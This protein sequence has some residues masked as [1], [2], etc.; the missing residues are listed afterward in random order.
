M[1]IKPEAYT[2]LALVVH[3][4]VTNSAKYGSLCDSNGRLNVDVASNKIGD[5]E[6][7]WRETGGPPVKPPRR[8][9]FGSTIIERSIPFELKGEAELR[10][11]L[12]GLEADFLVPSRFVEMARSRHGA[13]DAQGAGSPTTANAPAAS[14]GLPEHVLIVEDSMIIAL[15]TEECLKRLG[16]KYVTVEG[17]VNGALKAIENR[18]PDFALV[19]FNLGTESSEPVAEELKRRG[20]RFALATGYSDVSRRLDELGACA[21][22]HK[23][24]GIE[25]IEAL[26]LPEAKDEAA[27]QSPEEERPGDQ[28]PA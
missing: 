17:S 15:D 13:G 21:I 26:L 7:R 27:S 1:L 18:E 8:R 20:V 23:P 22:V 10:F 6:I 4:L 9:G 24:Y 5:L 2:V 19:D 25:D 11:K 14:A 28:P 12:S 16:V 3:E